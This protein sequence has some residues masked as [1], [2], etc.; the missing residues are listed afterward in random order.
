M[1]KAITYTAFTQKDGKIEIVQ[2]VSDERI[3][4]ETLTELRNR[5]HAIIKETING[6]PLNH[7]EWESINVLREDMRAINKV[8]ELLSECE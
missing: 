3:A 5:L 8:I 1:K 7:K 6:K 4:M 2:T